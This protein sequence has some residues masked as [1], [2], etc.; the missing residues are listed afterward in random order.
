VRSSGTEPLVRVMVEA[1]DQVTAESI[2][3]R[4]AQAVVGIHGGSIEGTH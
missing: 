1:A 2:A 4:V 3:I